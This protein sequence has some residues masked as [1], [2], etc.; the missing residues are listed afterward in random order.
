MNFN[1]IFSDWTMRWLF[2]SLPSA[3]PLVAAALLLPCRRRCCCHDVRYTGEQFPQLPMVP[4][5]KQ[6][7]LWNYDVVVASVC[8]ERT[9]EQND[10]E[11][12]LVNPKVNYNSQ[13]NKIKF[14][15]N[16]MTRVAQLNE[17]F[18]S[19]IFNMLH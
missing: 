14:Y 6:N 8:C 18:N 11:N 15:S 9:R 13:Q 19:K 12:F 7:M 5:V 4:Y 1:I 17:V 10:A 2:S 16:H 3:L